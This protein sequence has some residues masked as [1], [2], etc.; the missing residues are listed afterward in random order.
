MGAIYGVFTLI[1]QLA[2]FQD[3]MELI[4]LISPENRC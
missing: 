1:E 3:G 2:V 4:L